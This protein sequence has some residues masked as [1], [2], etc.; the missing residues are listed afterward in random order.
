MGS[1]GCC[2]NQTIFLVGVFHL[3][4]PN[5][6]TMRKS[7]WT[8][9][10]SRSENK[11][12]F[13]TPPSCYPGSMDEFILWAHEENHPASTTN[14]KNPNI[15]P[16]KFL[17]SHLYLFGD[18]VFF[19]TSWNICDFQTCWK[20]W[21]YLRRKPAHDGPSASLGHELWG[22]ENRF[23]RCWLLNNDF[24]P[25]VLKMIDFH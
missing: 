8:I 25:A 12:C 19:M 11:T 13:T 4:H 9:Y 6:K 7:T 23:F 24:W 18:D 2:N 10:P 14:G 15:S 21:R 1:E 20:R 5:L 16:R 3:N 22:W 17:D